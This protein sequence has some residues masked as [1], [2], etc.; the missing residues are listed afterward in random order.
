MRLLLWTAVLATA[1]LSLPRAQAP[2]QPAFAVASIKPVA[3]A[4]ASAGASSPDSFTH[5]DATLVDLIAFAFDVQDFQVLEGPA[6]IRDNR[7]AVSAKADAVVSPAAMRLMVRR[8]LGERFGLRTHAETREMAVYLLVTARQDGRL[9]ER[10][11]PSSIDC[12][13]ILAARTAAA[14]DAGAPPQCLWRIGF[15]AASALMTLDGAPLDRFARLLQPMLGRIVQDRTGLTGTFDLK[16][17][18]A[19]ERTAARFPLAP[20]GPGAQPA[21]DGLS[22]FTALEDQLGLKLEPA[23]APVPVIVVDAARPPEPD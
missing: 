23:R 18:F 12:P 22:L 6:W 10:M 17:E 4:P 9:G 21:R 14:P 19:P 2:D 16:L 15:M 13:A 5:P 11:T 8:L 7:Y 20:S 3:D 1:W